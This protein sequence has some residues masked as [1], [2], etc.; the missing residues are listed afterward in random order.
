MD[1]IFDKTRYFIYAVLYC[2]WVWNVRRWYLIWRLC[3]VIPYYTTKFF[4]KKSH[5]KFLRYYA[6]R[7]REIHPIVVNLEGGWEY[8]QADRIVDS[9]WFWY[10]MNISLYLLLFLICAIDLSY[11]AMLCLFLAP[12]IGSYI[13]LDWIKGSDETYLEYF[14]VFEN[15]NKNWFNRWQK[16][17]FLVIIGVPI[18][19]ALTISLMAFL[20]NNGIIVPY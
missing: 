7:S 10:S 18:S 6:Q 17:T 2:I 8:H 12:L 13:V 15:M 16:I 14:Q 11:I 3:D 20:L 4:I 1:S 5:R 9:I 19:L